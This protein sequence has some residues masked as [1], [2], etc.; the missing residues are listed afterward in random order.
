[1]ER[2]APLFAIKYA[3]MNSMENLRF[4]KEDYFHI[5]VFFMGYFILKE[6]ENMFPVFPY[7]IETLVKVWKNSKLRGN[8][9]P[10]SCSH[11]N[12]VSFS[13]T[14]TRVSITVWKYGK[15]LL[16]RKYCMLFAFERTM[17]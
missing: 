13:Q 17:R 12:S 2:F 15:C 5:L 6:T 4:G 1:M 3:T 14:F 10:G 16:F 8:I 7:V 9:R 11:F